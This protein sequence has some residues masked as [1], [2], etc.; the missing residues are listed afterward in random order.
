MT[1]DINT[2]S[3]VIDITA[4]A[5]S[6]VTAIWTTVKVAN[7]AIRRIGGN[8]GRNRNRRRNRRRSRRNRGPA[9][10]RR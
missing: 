5:I 6:I 8:T 3:T 4:N 2:I 9:P 1:I 7:A 10:P